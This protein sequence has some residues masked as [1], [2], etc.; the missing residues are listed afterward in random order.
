MATRP[1]N[2]QLL[3]TILY[4]KAKGIG[5]GLSISHSLTESLGGRLGIAPSSDRALFEVTL[6]TEDTAVS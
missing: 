6:P 3:G 1:I 5:M 4:Y 2:T